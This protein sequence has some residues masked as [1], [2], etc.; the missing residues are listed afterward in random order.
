MSFSVDYIDGQNQLINE[1]RSRGLYIDG[2]K[3]QGLGQ[4]RIVKVNGKVGVDAFTNILATCMV[5]KDNRWYIGNYRFT[6]GLQM[7]EKYI[8]A[9]DR[10]LFYN[11]EPVRSDFELL[12]LKCEVNDGD[13]LEIWLAFDFG[14]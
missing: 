14:I 2:W 10:I 5:K 9:G 7:L 8:H 1:L 3:I 4:I 6:T 13:N 12:D 11:S